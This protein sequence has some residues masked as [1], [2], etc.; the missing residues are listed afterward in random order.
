MG[1]L[2]CA[3]RFETEIMHFKHHTPGEYDLVFKGTG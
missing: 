3:W 1:D 2:T